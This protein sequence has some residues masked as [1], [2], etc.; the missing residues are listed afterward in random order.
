MK[1]LVRLLLL[2]IAL[3]WVFQLPASAES[4]Q[5]NLVP[6]D[7]DQKSVG[8]V[9]LKYNEYP[10]HHYKL[11][12][13]VDTSGDWMPWNWADGAGKQ[14]YIAL[15]EIINSIWNVNVLLANFTMK[16]VQEVFEL[17][18]ISNLVVQIG[19]A[20]QNIAGFGPGGFMSNGLWPLLVTFVIGIVG[21]WATYVG[22]VKRETSRAWSGLLSSIIIFVFA[23]GFFS[24]ASTIL[25]GINDWS[26]N[27]QSDI[28]AV[29]ASIVNPGASYTQEEGIATI[30]NQM[31]DL[32]VKKPYLL[33]QY[34]T[35]KVDEGRVNT[36][37]SV[38]PILDA[39]KRQEEAQK[40]V[41]EEDNSMMSIDGIS[42]RA[43]FVPLLFLANTIIGVFLLII[44]GTIIL[45]QMIFLVLVL[46][47]PV[48]LLMALVP[49][50]QQ[51]AFDW[52]MKV[53]HAQL[54][55]IAIALLLTILFGISAI[56]YRA[57]DTDDLGYLGM[58]ILQIICFVGIWAKRKELFSMVAT[59]V[60][61]VQSSTGATLQGYKQK[62]N[63]AKNTIRKARNVINQ[64]SGKGRVRNQPLAQRQVGQ[65]NIG[66]RDKDQLA[67]RQQQLKATKDG[68]K[69]SVSGTM[70]ADRRNKEFQEGQDM[71][72]NR[73][74]IEN[75]ATA[76]REQLM[77]RQV[78]KAAIGK[79]LNVPQS[80]LD[81]AREKAVDSKNDNV[82]NIEEL[83]RKR[84][85][86]AE[87]ALTDR[88]NIQDAQREAAP[89]V[90]RTEMRDVKLSDRTQSVR[91][92]N[93]MNQHSHEDRINNV[94]ETNRN[95]QENMTERE[96]VSRNVTKRTEH[97]SNIN[98]VSR[99]QINETINQESENITNRE[100][101]N[102]TER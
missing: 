90:E 37:L 30:R 28:L 83:R 45:Y 80:I 49:R 2:S 23:L 39:K 101:G 41:E 3:L 43:G 70:L 22:M 78:D 34:G 1:K 93:L 91:N 59:A 85:N 18:F 21:A 81:V 60:N 65:S 72:K 66:V 56:L 17:D 19:Q 14:I 20:V 98:N 11:D 24:N 33:M 31:F 53:L 97:V 76:D 57:T 38:D 84:G 77:D 12:T 54:M 92:I 55:K 35:T 48:P 87:F 15:M 75:A 64:T 8:E 96:S 73:S 62:Y 102:R 46:F 86:L 9:E 63:E 7:S 27:L 10:Q 94:T 32:M 6:Q 71:Y 89:S 51:T 42:Q 4:L 50:W 95:V 79:K 52:A 68:L 69:S 13:Y 74:G 40:E 99:E 16:I 5:D 29:F 88:T 58:M 44:S 47:A 67:E 61:N 82:M 100:R 25:K 26:S 36:I